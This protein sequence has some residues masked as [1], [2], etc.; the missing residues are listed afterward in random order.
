MLIERR[1]YTLKPGGLGA[2]WRAQE[3]RGYESVRPIL[4]RLIGYFSAVSGPADQVV[5]LYRYDTFDDW[6]TR[7]HGL[8][9]V[10]SLEPY[11]KTVRALMTFQENAFLSPAPLDALSPIWNSER[12]WLPLNGPLFEGEHA[13]LVLV[14]ESTHLLMPGT[15]PAYWAAWANA[16]VSAMQADAASQLG[17]FVGVVGQQ[18]EVRHYRVHA[19]FEARQAD[20]AA[21]TS[22]P[23]WKEFIHAIAPLCVRSERK[24]LQPAP[25]A[26]LSPLFMQVR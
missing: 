17:S 7:L 25:M 11:F 23:R 22:D 19:S 1:C 2:F 26:P 5:H 8:Y 3:D 21:L 24:L 18:H 4:E 13:S 14:E 15:L 12:D 20:N 10:A 16:G 6:Q 9:A